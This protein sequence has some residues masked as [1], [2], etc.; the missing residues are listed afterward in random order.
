M[1]EKITVIN[2]YLRKNDNHCGCP[3][4][5]LIA[6]RYCRLIVDATIYANAAINCTN[7]KDVLL[8]S[9]MTKLLL[10]AIY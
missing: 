5:S 6:D 2:K 7:Y 3:M 9:F 4:K 8:N 10:L 1:T